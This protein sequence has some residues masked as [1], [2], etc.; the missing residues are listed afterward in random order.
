MTYGERPSPIVRLGCLPA[1]V[2]IL[3]VGIPATF[4]PLLGECFDPDGRVHACPHTGITLLTTIAVM[5]ALALVITW[6]TN[7]MVDA[8]AQRGRS[9]AWGVAGGFAVAVGLTLL[10]FVLAV[11]FR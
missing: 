6:T 11:T 10:L 4:L 2:F 7:K 3:V 8:L 5:A 1:A 9:A